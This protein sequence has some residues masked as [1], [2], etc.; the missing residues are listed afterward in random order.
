ME[1][2][3]ITPILF[4]RK[5]L[6]LVG[7]PI[8]TI[9]GRKTDVEACFW[10][11]S[12]TKRRGKI[13]ISSWNTKDAK[14]KKWILGTVEPH[15]IL[16]LKPYKTE[17]EM[18]E[19]LKTVYH[20]G[21]ATRQYQLEFEIAQYTQGSGTIQDYYS[22]FLNLWTEYDEIKYADMSSVALS[23]I[24]KLQETSFL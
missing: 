12:K 20:R 2:S 19:Y 1:K 10:N 6:H 23:E 7:F 17:K 11:R 18:W 13:Y 14:I 16:N 24:Q 21:N 8:P 9:P 15:L 5:K 22:G 4:S 3:E